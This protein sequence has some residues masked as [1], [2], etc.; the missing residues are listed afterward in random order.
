MLVF[1][2]TAIALI[3]SLNP[4]A[5]AVQLYLLE[6]P[7]RIQCAI[8]FITGIWLTHWMLGLAG[9]SVFRGL[10]AEWFNPAETGILFL[11]FLLGIGLIVSGWKL[12]RFLIKCKSTVA[13]HTVSLLSEY[14][15]HRRIQSVSTTYAFLLGISMA[16]WELPTALPYAAAIAL[17][18][19]ESLS[20]TSTMFLLGFYNFIVV[21]PL[22]LLL[23]SAFLS[24]RQHAKMT[25]WLTQVISQASS[26]LLRI[27]CVTF[28]IVLVVEFWVHILTNQLV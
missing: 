10:F 11:Q 26:R 17:L 3:D 24:G 20:Q 2:L 12:G 15:P 1:L 19:R 27:F 13:D 4:T 6:T 7:R 8:A 14:K 9:V 21:L 18:A 25:S 28:G 16:V 23:V 5:I 22:L